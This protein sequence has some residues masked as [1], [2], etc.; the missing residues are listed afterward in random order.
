[1]TG[2]RGFVLLVAAFFLAGCLPVLSTNPI[3]TTVGFAEDPALYGTWRGQDT[4]GKDQ[5]AAFL[6]ILKG[7]DGQA[8]AALILAGGNSDDE[9][10]IYALRPARL[11]ANRFLNAV[12]QTSN[13][14]PPDDRLRNANIPL[15]YT[16]AGKTLTLSLLDEDKTADAIRAGQLQ[17][18]IGPG[19]NDDITITANATVLDGVM[20]KPEAVTLFKILLVLTK[21]E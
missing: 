9:W 18:V 14:A 2:L 17:G 8:T 15:L 13:G 6:H 16:I 20:A 11:G 4:N 5:R 19:K 1:M 7:R 3:G 10:E 12:L 21:A